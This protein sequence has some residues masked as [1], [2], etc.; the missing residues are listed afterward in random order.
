ML[1]T[2]DKKIPFIQIQ[3]DIKTRPNHRAKF[4]SNRLMHPRIWTFLKIIYIS[5]ETLQTIDRCNLSHI[6]FEWDA[7]AKL[8]SAE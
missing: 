7:A 5:E 4:I 1:K 6:F 2:S 8:P 3:F